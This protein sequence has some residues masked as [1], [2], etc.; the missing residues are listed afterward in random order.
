MSTKVASNSYTVRQKLV[1]EEEIENTFTK[2][3]KIGYQ[4]VELD[5]EGILPTI[6]VSRLKEI[7]QQ[8]NIRPFSAHEDYEFLEAGL[9][10]VISNCKDLGIEYVV[11]PNLPRERFCKDARGFREGAKNMVE[12]ADELSKKGLKFA[13]HN[14][15][16]EFERYDGKIAMDIL[17]DEPGPK[18]LVQIDIYWVQYGGGDPAEWISRYRGRVPFIHAK[19]YCIV[20]GKPMYAEVGEGNLNWPSILK[21]C[22]DA[23][24]QW[25]VVEQDEC[26]RDSIDCLKTSKENLEKMGIT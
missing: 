25:Y 6:D 5:L 4:A 24:V 26:L 9:D 1:S 15:A 11:I 13:Y 22:K 7:L 14:H 18:Y 20:D 21:A 2:I 8:A 23:G 12:F 16:K 17:Y 3:G 10:R 19:D